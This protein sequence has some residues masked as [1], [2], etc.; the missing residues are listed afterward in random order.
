MGQARPTVLVVDDD[1]QVLE[2]ASAVVEALGYSVIAAR[3]G[4]EAY[5]SFARTAP[6]RSCSRT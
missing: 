5:R 6:S 2:I 3:S 4:R 1:P